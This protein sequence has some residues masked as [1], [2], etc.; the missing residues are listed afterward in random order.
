MLDACHDIAQR[1]ITLHY[2]K[3]RGG[4]QYNYAQQNKNY[5]QQNMN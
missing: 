2:R 5:A 4:S 3:L 1:Y